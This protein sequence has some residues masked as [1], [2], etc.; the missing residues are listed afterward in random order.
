MNFDFSNVAEVNK[1]DNSK[2]EFVSYDDEKIIVPVT[3]IET[4]EKALEL[5]EVEYLKI[6][7]NLKSLDDL[8]RMFGKGVF[9]ELRNYEIEDAFHKIGLMG[10]RIK[11]IC[12]FNGFSFFD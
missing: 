10:Y 3:P 12:P 7:N 4:R 2:I 6:F 8:P 5:L 1:I 9:P 11:S